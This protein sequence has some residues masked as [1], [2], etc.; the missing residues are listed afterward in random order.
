MVEPLASLA[1][2]ATRVLLLL[3]RLHAVALP[4][5][6]ATAHVVEKSPWVA[7]KRLLIAPHFAATA[8]LNSF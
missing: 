4:N 7:D 3:L 5:M 2:L 1:L 8:A 6:L